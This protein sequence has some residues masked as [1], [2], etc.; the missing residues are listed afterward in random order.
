MHRV[1]L[2]APLVNQAAAVAFLVTGSSKRYALQ[3]VWH[4]PKD[5]HRFPAQI[6]APKGELHWWV[7]DAAV[8]TQP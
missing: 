7:D 3:Q 4:G 6:I 5:V 2:T 8:S 1:T